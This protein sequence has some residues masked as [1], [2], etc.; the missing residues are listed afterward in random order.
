MFV[1]MHELL[2]SP[3][4]RCP[5]VCREHIIFLSQAKLSGDFDN[6]PNWLS[7]TRV[8][9]PELRENAFVCLVSSME[10]SQFY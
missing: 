9:A 8:M 4:V 10:V 6:W 1:L 2:R 7:N 5:T 3:F